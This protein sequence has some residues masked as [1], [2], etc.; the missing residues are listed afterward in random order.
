MDLMKECYELIPHGSS[1]AISRKKLA[2]MLHTSDRQLYSLIQSLRNSGKVICSNVNTSRTTGY[3]LPVDDKE[4]QEY[5]NKQRGKLRTE[6]K[7]LLAQVTS[8]NEQQEGSK[9]CTLL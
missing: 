5:F 4:A 6:S 7:I 1:N 8:W 3:Y 9:Q 2:G